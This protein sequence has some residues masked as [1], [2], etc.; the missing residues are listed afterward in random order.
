[1]GK[2]VVNEWLSG[3][4]FYVPVKYGNR[5]PTQKPHTIHLLFLCVFFG[6]FRFNMVTDAQ[7]QN[8]I[9]FTCYYC[10]CFLVASGGHYLMVCVCYG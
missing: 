1:M 2:M 6:S 4:F 7:L 8:L 5:C 10:A 3:K 9:L